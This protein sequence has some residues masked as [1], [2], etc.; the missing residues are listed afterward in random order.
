MSETDPQT[1]PLD[2]PPMVARADRQD[3]HYEDDPNQLVKAVHQVKP[4]TI[5]V[6]GPA[7]FDQ[8]GR[9]EDTTAFDVAV[10][11]DGPSVWEASPSRDAE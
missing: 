6:Q 5:P 8:R 4:P 7:L 9:A 10:T 1:N 3:G 11:P 2:E